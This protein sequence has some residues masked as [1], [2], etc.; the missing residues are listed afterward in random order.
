MVGSIAGPL[1]L[2]NSHM[3]HGVCYWQSPSVLS[4]QFQ[5]AITTLK[6]RSGGLHA[7]FWNTNNR[8]ECCPSANKSREKN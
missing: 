7:G 3:S 6:R 4:D 1:I 5:E 2:G 8:P